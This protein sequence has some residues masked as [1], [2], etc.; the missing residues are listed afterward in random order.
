MASPVRVEQ[1]RPVAGR[2]LDQ[3]L[4]LG[5]HDLAPATLLDRIVDRR[6][7]FIRITELAELVGELVQ[8]QVTGSGPPASPLHMPPAEHDRTAMMRLAE[9]MKAALRPVVGAQ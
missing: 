7:A 5:P 4:E 1:R 6:H 8:D 2:V 3:L 9:G